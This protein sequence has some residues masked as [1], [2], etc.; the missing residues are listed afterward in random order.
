M[1]IT[2]ML[3][4]YLKNPLGIETK[5]PLLSYT[6][7]SEDQNQ[8]QTAY[9]IL[10][11]STKELLHKNIGD[12]WDS[13][14]VPLMKIIMPL[15]TVELILSSRQELF[16]KVKVWDKNDIASEWSEIASWEMGLLEQNDW[17]AHWIG[18]GDTADCNKSAAPQVARDF[19][20]SDVK[21]V[22]KARAYISGLGLFQ[23]SL[24]GEQLDDTLL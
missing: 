8:C 22:V 16:W 20:V 10:V 4:Q 7:E 23:A 18:Q 3:V 17:K 15:R 2:N 5:N 9:C 14:K 11:S 6:L 21:N 13:G 1:N 24:N 19:Q 12:L